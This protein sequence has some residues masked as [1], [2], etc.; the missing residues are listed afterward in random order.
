MLLV[1]VAQVTQVVPAV[2]VLLVVVLLAQAVEAQTN[3]KVVQVTGGLVRRL[4]LL[5]VLRV[6]ALI[7]PTLQI[8]E[9]PDQPATQEQ[10]ETR[11]LVETL[12]R[13]LALL[14]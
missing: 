7:L 8:R 11:V 3:Q 9:M 12:V 1:T 4:L 14:D 13:L 5:E 6:L 2:L 10:Q